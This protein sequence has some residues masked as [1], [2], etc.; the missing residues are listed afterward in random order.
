[1][2][3]WLWRELVRKPHRLDPT[4]WEQE[5]WKRYE[6]LLSSSLQL[7]KGWIGVDLMRSQSWMDEGNEKLQTLP[8]K[9]LGKLKLG[10]PSSDGVS[11]KM[12]RSVFE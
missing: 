7:H 12:L 3:V 1:M 8:P 4:F 9:S 2:H 10:K 6:R 5:I 11:A